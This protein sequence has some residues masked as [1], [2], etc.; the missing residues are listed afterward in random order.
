VFCN[1]I[2]NSLDFIKPG[3]GQITI[4]INEIQKNGKLKSYRLIHQDNGPGV[5]PEFEDK[6]FS[7]FFT[8]KEKDRGTG[9]GLFIVK[10]IISNHKGSIMLEQAHS[11]GARFIIEMEAYVEES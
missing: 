5:P 4:T 3:E 9:L 8:T 10:N 1:L 7:P 11:D 2:N 6:I